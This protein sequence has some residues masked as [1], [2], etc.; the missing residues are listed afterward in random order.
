MHRIEKVHKFLKNIGKQQAKEL[1]FC[2]ANMQKTASI[3]DLVQQQSNIGRAELLQVF[4][5]NLETMMDN[6]KW[7]IKAVTTPTK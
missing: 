3:V 1:V 6:V 5:G 2:R 7:Q 4:N